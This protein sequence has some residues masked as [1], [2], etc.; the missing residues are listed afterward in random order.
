MVPSLHIRRDLIV[1]FIGG[2]LL[3]I[4][5]SIQLAHSWEGT[6]STISPGYLEGFQGNL[7]RVYFD[8]KDY[9][10][11]NT[12]SDMYLFYINGSCIGYA[13]ATG[14]HDGAPS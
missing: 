7:T 5:I 10:R 1:A 2:L 13:N 8:T 9:I 6:N 4:P 12:T 14:F 11:Y 3:S